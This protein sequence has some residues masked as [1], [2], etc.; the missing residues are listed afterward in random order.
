MSAKKVFFCS[1]N[2]NDYLGIDSSTKEKVINLSGWCDG[3]FVSYSFK[4]E[5]SIELAET[6]LNEINK[7]K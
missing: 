5:T 3:S 4:L 2:K 1:D 6:I 7:I